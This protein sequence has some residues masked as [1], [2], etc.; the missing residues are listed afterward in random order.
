MMNNNTPLMQML[1]T[2]M[3]YTTQRQGVLAHNIANADTPQYRTQDLK[4][5]DFDSM[6]SGS[7]KGPEFRAAGQMRLTNNKHMMGT[8]AGASGFRAQEIRD[9]Q[10]IT[11][12]KNNVVL[13]EEM[14][15]ISD[16]GAQ[17]QIS[18]SLM[19]KFTTMY[20]S[21]LGQR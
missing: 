10:E 18:N 14:A 15:K 1:S 6:V 8:V 13:E 11:P 2:N 3:R 9:A 17:F 5:P 16:T 19:K 4:S 7:S 12:V 20:R 21:A